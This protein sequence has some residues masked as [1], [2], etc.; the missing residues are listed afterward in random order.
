MKKSVKDILEKTR[1]VDPSSRDSLRGLAEYKSN[2][3]EIHEAVSKGEL[4]GHWDESWSRW[5]FNWKGKEAH[6]CVDLG[7][8]ARFI[9]IS[10][11]WF[12]ARTNKKEINK[13]FKGM[14]AVAL[15]SKSTN[16]NEARRSENVG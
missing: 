14:R 10:E 8:D 12:E 7:G 5:Y 4:V 15:K 6:L 16:N 9:S 11:H 1:F 3:V 2:I 13:L